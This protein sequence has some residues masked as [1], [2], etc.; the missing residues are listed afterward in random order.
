MPNRTEGWI[1]YSSEVADLDD[2][3]RFVRNKTRSFPQRFNYRFHRV[4]S[5]LNA[6]AGVF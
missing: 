2:G 1:D 3:R 6:E 4:L 5:G